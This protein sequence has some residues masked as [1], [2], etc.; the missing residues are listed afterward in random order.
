VTV[1]QALIAQAN[2]TVETMQ[3]LNIA[4][5]VIDES[6]VVVQGLLEDNQ[7][8]QELCTNKALLA[9]Y[10][11]TVM[12]PGGPLEELIPND[13]LAADVAAFQGTLPS[14][15][16]QMA[17]ARQQQ[18]PQGYQRPAFNVQAP[19][20]EQAPQENPADFWNQFNQFRRSNPSK[21]YVMLSQATPQQLASRALISEDV[22]YGS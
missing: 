4:N 5:T 17:A 10:V 18:L 14:D 9:D 19:G 22:P 1:E 16:P 21:A 2:Q 12:G 3:Q 6:Q 15:V 7:A 13:A 8:Y 20:G 11:N